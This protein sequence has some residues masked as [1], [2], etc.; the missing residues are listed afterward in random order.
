MIKRDLFYKNWCQE[1]GQVLMHKEGTPIITG[2][3][4]MNFIHIGAC[5]KNA[6]S[7]TFVVVVPKEESA[8]GT[9]VI[10]LLV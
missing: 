6:S 7:K 5:C 9:P 10:L 2:T 1:F 8:G 4:I 3:D